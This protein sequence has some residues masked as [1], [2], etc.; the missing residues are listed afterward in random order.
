MPKTYF[1]EDV[2]IIKKPFKA[3]F[4]KILILAC[5]IFVIIATVFTSIFLS[6]A[7]TIGNITTAIVYGGKDIKLNKHQMYMVTLGNYSDYSEAEKVALGSTIQGA[8][9][10]I[11]DLN[12]EYFVVGNIYKSREDANVVKDNLSTSKYNIEVIELSFP[13][14]NLNFDNMENKNV[15]LIKKAIDYVD[16][17]YENLYNYSIKFDKGETNNFA[18]CSGISELRGE[19][20]VQIANV[21]SLITKENLKLQTLINCLTKIDEILNVAILKTIDNSSTNYSL[22][23]AI[24]SVV[25]EKYNLYKSL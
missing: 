19:C 16:E 18:V 8:S 22:K 11:W 6:K 1:Y 24:V 21:Q 2:K 3:K 4:K 12:N 25:Y 15:N 9:G 14:C 13:K 23:N 10:Y 20:K 5:C 17:L 7:L